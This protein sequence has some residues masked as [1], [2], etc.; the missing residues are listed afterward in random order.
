MGMKLGLPHRLKVFQSEVLRRMFG[1]K[2]YEHGNE[3]LHNI[4]LDRIL[5]GRLNHGEC[6]GLDMQHLVGRGA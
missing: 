2:K 3:K 6:D 1:P 4:T 5:L